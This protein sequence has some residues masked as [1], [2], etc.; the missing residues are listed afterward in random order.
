M[1]V[2]YAVAPSCGFR[3]DAPGPVL[4]RG[5]RAGLRLGLP[6]RVALVGVERPVARHALVFCTAATIDPSRVWHPFQALTGI[7]R[8]TTASTDEVPPLCVGVRLSPDFNA[9]AVAAVTTLLDEGKRPSRCSEGRLGRREHR[10]V[11][12][13]VEVGR[14]PVSSVLRVAGAG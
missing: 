6:V 3:P 12:T 8:R 11:L 13:R 2:R 4:R 9:L 10:L 7:S 5:F 14:W 1:A